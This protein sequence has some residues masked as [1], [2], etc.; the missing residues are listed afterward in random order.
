MTAHVS[1][2]SSCNMLSPQLLPAHGQVDCSLAPEGLL[3]RGLILQ[4]L[5]LELITWHSDR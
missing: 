2:D 1:C 5:P 3:H 4:T